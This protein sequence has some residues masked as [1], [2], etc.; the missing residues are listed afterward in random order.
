M[1]H[2]RSK[3]K[4]CKT[5]HANTSSKRPSGWWSAGVSLRK[6]SSSIAR[7]EFSSSADAHRAT[8]DVIDELLACLSCAFM[9]GNNST[10]APSNRRHDNILRLFEHGL[11]FAIV[12]DKPWKMETKVGRFFN[13]LLDQ[14]LIRGSIWQ[15]YTTDAMDSSDTSRFRYLCPLLS[16]PIQNSWDCPLVH[17]YK[18]RHQQRPISPIV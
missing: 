10:F 12:G 17:V 6:M 15:T 18:S 16:F 9:P 4:I 1:E 13:S 14:S 2:R 5:F 8:I 3:S 7:F 11:V